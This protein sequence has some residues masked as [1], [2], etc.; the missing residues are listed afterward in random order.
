MK[1]TTKSQHTPGPWKVTGGETSFY[2]MAVR[3]EVSQICE[4]HTWDVQKE[5][6]ARLIAAA[7]DL[8]E[9][10]KA[11]QNWLREYHLSMDSPIDD[12]LFD[13]DDTIQ[14]AIAKAEGNHND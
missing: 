5:A 1:T 7:P 13:L 12:G 6:N 8:L 3:S 9:A 10:L 4:F 14:Q 11:A 2:P